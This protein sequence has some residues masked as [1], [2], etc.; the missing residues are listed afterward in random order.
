MSGDFNFYRYV[1]NSPISFRDSSGLIQDYNGDG[2]ISGDEL[3]RS[4]QEGKQKNDTMID[5]LVPLY[6]DK[7][8]YQKELTKVLQ[9]NE[10]PLNGSAS[11]GIQQQVYAR[12][13][14]EEKEE[15]WTA[16]LG[17]SGGFDLF[18]FGA[19]A[20][21]GIFRSRVCNDDGTTTLRRGIYTTKEY[22]IDVGKDSV[23]MDQ[24]IKG[25]GN[26]AKAVSKPN[27]DLGATAIY[28]WKDSETV[29]NGNSLNEGVS[30]GSYSLSR[31][32]AQNED[33]TYSPAAV[34][35]DYDLTGKDV[36]FHDKK[37]SGYTTC[38]EQYVGMSWDNWDGWDPVLEDDGKWDCDYP[39][40]FP[41][42]DV[43]TE[44]HSEAVENEKENR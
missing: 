33:G 4:F 23:K 10:L 26:R 34:M 29:L 37:G 40:F 32:S 7:E 21:G 28:G 27:V 9:E 41:Y 16:A 18:G 8:A 12:Q 44:T 31:G 39:I 3:S 6:N 22:G 43:P 15:P 1:G 5:R 14:K 19:S 25:V 38:E 30:A 13:P 35:V 42:G 20:E 11:A 24:S 2:Y 36:G 17:L